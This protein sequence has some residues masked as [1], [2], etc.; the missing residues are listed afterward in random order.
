[1][2]SKRTRN[3]VHNKKKVYSTLSRSWNYSNT[4]DHTLSYPHTG[5]SLLFFCF[6]LHYPLYFLVVLVNVILSLLFYPHLLL[7]EQLYTL[8]SIL[9]H[10]LKRRSCLRI[11]FT[12]IHFIVFLDF[13]PQKL[14]FVLVLYFNYFFVCFLLYFFV[15]FA[16]KNIFVIDSKTKFVAYLY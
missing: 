14:I 16:S 10:L 15:G 7:S 13:F 3:S 2:A 6:L 11:A 5:T 12:V 8:L 4:C 1:M 9:A